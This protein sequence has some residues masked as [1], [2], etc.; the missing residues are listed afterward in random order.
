MSD[1]LAILGHL[2]LMVALLALGIL[3]RRLGAA[4]RAPRYYRGF[5]VAAAL[6]AVS[7]GALIANALFQLADAEALINSIEWVLIYNGLP[8]L[9]VTIGVYLGW[10]Y[11][12]WLLAERG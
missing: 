6:Q 9:A 10:R 5:F 8:A 4:T 7:T 11:W 12:S 1:L 2:S 3:S